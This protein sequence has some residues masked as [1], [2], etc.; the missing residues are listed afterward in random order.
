MAVEVEKLIEEMP[1][2]P[3]EDKRKLYAAIEK[4][5][6]A[7]AEG[8]KELEERPAGGLPEWCNV[9]EG[10]SEEEIA[11]MEQVVLTRADMTRAT[12]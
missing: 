11:E 3:P 6:E 4:E 1:G 9:Y 10:L 7:P 5:M 12:G 8:E 2:L